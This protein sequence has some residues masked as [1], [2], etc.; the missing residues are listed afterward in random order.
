M[1]VRRCCHLLLLA[2]LTSSCASTSTLVTRHQ[3]APGVGPVTHVL[4]V[5]QT[6]DAE[7]RTQWEKA[8]ASRLPSA[9]IISFSHQIWPDAV[10]ERE[11]LLQRSVSLGADAVLSVE[12]AGLLLLPPQMPPE[13]VVSEERRASSDASPRQRGFQI[14]LSGQA[15]DTEGLPDPEIEFQLQRPDGSVLWNALVRSHEA[16]Q[17]EALARSQCRRVAKTLKREGL[18]P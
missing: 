7:R 15:P 9:V 16:N 3:A 1:S 13:N 12:L 10:P 6:P 4:L 5:A 14:T 17:I 8:C 18:L 11:A 2:A